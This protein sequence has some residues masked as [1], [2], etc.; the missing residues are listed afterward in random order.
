[1]SNVAWYGIAGFELELTLPEGANVAHLLP[2]A[3]PFRLSEPTQTPILRL[4]TSG[5]SAEEKSEEG[6]L[7]SVDRNDLGEVRLYRRE[8]GY[9]ICSGF[10]DTPYR[11]HLVLNEELSQATAEIDWEDPRPGEAL[12]ALLRI[13]YS[14]AVLNHQAVSI[15][16]SAICHA[17]EAILFLGKSGTGKS[18]HARLWLTHAEACSLLNDD[19][20]TL[21]WCQDRLMAYGTPWS[22]K[23]PCYRNEGFP[24]RGIVRLSQAAENRFEPLADQ[25]AF[26]A[27]LPSCSLLRHNEA[28]ED[29]F[30]SLLGQIIATTRVAHL[31]CRP[32]REAY[33]CCH[34]G[35]YTTATPKTEKEEQ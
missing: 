32:D 21:R 35:L 15:H 28:I 5:L 17:G 31:G 8:R 3:E 20:P 11:H 22:G 4:A 10:L 26:L 29:R 2:N 12:N 23:T 19:N 33:L 7:L 18:T 27:V 25:R 16:A 1:M 34:A 24:V 13:G 9:Y 6:T 14:L 30:Y